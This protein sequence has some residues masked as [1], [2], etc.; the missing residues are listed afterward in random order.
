MMMMY[1]ALPIKIL[2]P[3]PI[4]HVNVKKMW[5]REFSIKKSRC[6]GDMQIQNRMQGVLLLHDATVWLTL[7]EF[8][9]CKST[10]L[11]VRRMGWIKV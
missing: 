6:H 2:V 9:C 4:T 8:Y 7:D 10:L 1:D 3:I 5:T 11:L